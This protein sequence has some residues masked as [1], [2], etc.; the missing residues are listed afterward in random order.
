MYAFSMRIIFIYF[1]LIGTLFADNHILEQENFEAI[2]PIQ[3]NT[4][5]YS[6]PEEF[7]LAGQG[8]KPFYFDIN[9]TMQSLS[10]ISV[11]G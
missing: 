5:Y 6:N 11:S 8:V 9:L 4:L 3:L 7:Q 2:D 10:M 1:L